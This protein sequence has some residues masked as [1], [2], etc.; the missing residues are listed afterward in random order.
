MEA[1]SGLAQAKQVRGIVLKRSFGSH[2]MFRS[3]KPK[4]VPE[5]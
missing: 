4:L 5:H 2:S 1:L 3:L